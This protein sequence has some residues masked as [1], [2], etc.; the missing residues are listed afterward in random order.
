MAQG[1][2]RAERRYLWGPDLTVC[3]EDGRFFHQVPPEGGQ[4]AHWCD[5][6]QYEVSYDFRA[7]P[8]WQTRWRVVGPRKDY[9]MV[10]WY[11]KV[12]E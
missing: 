12:P 4:A 11:R 5:P 9:A 8:D 6:D 7:W 2:F 10:S 1:R 3:F